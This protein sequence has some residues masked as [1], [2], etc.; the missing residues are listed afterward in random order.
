VGLLA[1]ASADCRPG[2][3]PAPSPSTSKSTL[4]TWCLN[5]VAAVHQMPQSRW[6]YLNFSGTGQA[7]WSQHDQISLAVPQ[8][9]LNTGQYV[10]I[11]PFSTFLASD[12]DRSFRH[13]EAMTSSASES[14]FTPMHH[15]MSMG[16]SANCRP[17]L[18]CRA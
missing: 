17:P 5:L 10:P 15:P 11:Y 9:P 4:I 16:S 1:G 2:A 14:C 3:E 18:R 12:L 8:L 13:P 7:Y 6:Q